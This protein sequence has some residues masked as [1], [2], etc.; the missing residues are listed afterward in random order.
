VLNPEVLDFATGEKGLFIATARVPL[1]V[2]NKSL[3]YHVRLFLDHFTLKPDLSTPVPA[4]AGGKEEIYYDSYGRGYIDRRLR[5][6]P[7][8]PKGTPV[9]MELLCRTHFTPLE[10]A[11]GKARTQWNENRRKAYSGSL[12]HFLASL[13]SN[14]SESEGFEVYE[15]CPTRNP[16]FPTVTFNVD[17]DTLLTKGDFSFERKLFFRNALQVTFRKDDAVSK[18]FVRL[19]KPPVTIY[20]NGVVAVPLSLTTYGYWAAQRMADMLPTDYAPD[21]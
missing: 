4:S 6:D 2:E 19:S 8:I 16:N 1:E 10:P 21:D 14:R 17:V 12:R 7:I 13:A 20:I 9:T 18:S 3:G 15:L 5:P 11:D